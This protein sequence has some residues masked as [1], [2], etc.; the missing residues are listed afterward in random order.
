M[1]NDIK[2]I[3]IDDEKMIAAAIKRVLEQYNFFCNFYTNSLD[4]LKSLKETDYAVAILD[5]LMPTLNGGELL[6][7]I[8]V[9]K[10]QMKVIM[11]TA[12]IDEYT[13]QSLRERGAD[14]VI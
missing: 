14:G 11:I 2:I 10:P 6:E 5:F 13:Q 9:N 12:Y 7:W 3:I 4:G 8:K 1:K